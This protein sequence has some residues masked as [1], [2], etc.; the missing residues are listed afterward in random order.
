MLKNKHS[1]F[2]E[3]NYELTQDLSFNG[4]VNAKLTNH[5]FSLVAGYSL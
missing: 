3:L 5:N 1:V 2:M 4:T